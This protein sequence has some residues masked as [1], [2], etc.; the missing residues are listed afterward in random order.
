MKL[1]ASEY[2]D[3]GKREVNEDSLLIAQVD[4]S[5]G[6]AIMAAVADGI[7]GLSE[8]EVASGYILEELN[9]CFGDELIG[10]IVHKKSGRRIIRCLKHCLYEINSELRTYADD[11]HIM[12]GSTLSLIL[13]YRN[14]YIFVQLGDSA[15]YKCTRNSVIQM[16]QKHITESGGVN[17]CIGSFGYMEPD[18]GYGKISGKVGFLVATDGFYKDMQKAPGFWNPLKMNGTAMA[19]KRL[20]QMGELI[21]KKQTDNASAV[22]ICCY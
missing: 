21:S 5:V 15:I 4:T 14:K 19:E 17:R 8:G 16:T 9:R 13:I 22:Y 18:I 10:L 1:F 6:S 3:I 2:W 12:L 20:R 7:G 11:K